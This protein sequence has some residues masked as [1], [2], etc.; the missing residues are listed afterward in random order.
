MPLYPRDP[1]SLLHSHAS[2]GPTSDDLPDSLDTYSASSAYDPNGSNLPYQIVYTTSETNPESLLNVFENIHSNIIATPSC[3]SV[4]MTFILDTPLLIHFHLQEPPPP[5]PVPSLHRFL[6]RFPDWRGTLQQFSYSIEVPLQPGVNHVVWCKHR[7]KSYLFLDWIIF[8]VII[9]NNSYKLF[10]NVFTVHLK[11][12][13]NL[14]F[15]EYIYFCSIMQNM[16]GP[17]N[18][19][20]QN[21]FKILVSI[22]YLGFFFKLLIFP[23]PGLS[24]WT[25]YAHK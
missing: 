5:P 16:H 4:A 18:T 13:S 10:A 19:A 9:L 3:H 20:L 23:D 17:F 25:V 15:L 1:S 12:P 2:G 11:T 7:S 8:K 14:W 21:I 6:S 22:I 24:W